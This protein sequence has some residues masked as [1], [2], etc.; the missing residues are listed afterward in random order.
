[1]VAAGLNTGVERE[2]LGFVMEQK[3][4]DKVNE[5]QKFHLDNGKSEGTDRA[6]KS[7]P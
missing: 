5:K 6:A 3:F 7:G 2:R 1:M 4:L